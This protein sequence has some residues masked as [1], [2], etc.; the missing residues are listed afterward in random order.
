MKSVNHSFFILVFIFTIYAQTSAENLTITINANAFQILPGEEGFSAIEMEDF[1]AVSTA[2]KPQMPVKSF[3][4]AIPPGARVNHVEI[5]ANHRTEIQGQYK[6]QPV[7]PMLQ[8]SGDELSY[9]SSDY[10]RSRQEWQE[11]YQAVY[12]S[13]ALFPEKIGV[14]TNQGQWRKYHYVRV[15]FYPLQYNPRTE[16]L[17]H[18]ASCTVS[19]DYGMP[20]PGSKTWKDSHKM[21]SDNVLDDI[22]SKRIV[23]FEEAQAWYQPDDQEK[24]LNAQNQ[25]N[26][27]IIV[28]DNTM[29]GAI[30]NFKNWKEKL[31]F[32]VKVVTLDSIFTYVNG[33]D[34]PERIWNFLQQNYSGE[35]WGIRYVLLIGDIDVL[36]MRFLCPNNNGWPYSSDFYYANL[37]QNWDVDNDD[38]WGEPY[39]DNLDA[40]PDVLVGRI[41]SNSPMT[42]TSILNNYISFEQ[43][44]GAWKRHAL[45]SMGIMDYNSSGK[46]DCA[47]LGENHL[48]KSI[49]D[50]RGW[51]YTTQYEKDGISPSTFT[52]TGALSD[53]NF[54]G[55][56]GPEKNGVVNAVA[57][58][59][60]GGMAGH[61][62]FQDINGDGQCNYSKDESVNEATYDWFSRIDNIPANVQSVVFLCGCST[63]PLISADNTQLGSSLQ[64][65]RTPMR[66]LGKTYILNGAP[67]VIASTAGSDYRQNWSKPQDGAAQSLNYYFFNELITK[68]LPAGDAFYNATID[69][70]D[71]H[72]WKR[73]VRVFNYY[74]DPSIGLK[75]VDYRPGG[76]DVV[77]HDSTNWGFAVEY[78]SNGDMYTAVITTSNTDPGHIQIY[79]SQ[80]HGST[81]LKWN[82]MTGRSPFLD[83]EV[84][85]G[86]WGQDEFED[87]RLLVFYSTS[88]GTQHVSRFPLSGGVVQNV[89]ISSE[90][91]QNDVIRLTAAR[92]PSS[93]NYNVYFAYEVFDS[94][95]GNITIKVARSLNN[96]TTWQDWDSFPGYSTPSIDAGVNKNVYLAVRGQNLPHHVHIFRSTDAGENWS[97]NTNVTQNFGADSYGEPT[98]AASSDPGAP[99]VWVAYPIWKN[100]RND[101]HYTFSKNS[102]ANWDE[103]YVLAQNTGLSNTV[104]MKGYNA[105]PNQW[106]NVAFINTYAEPQ[107]YWRYSAGTTPDAWS[108][109]RIVNDFEAAAFTTQPPRLV[110]SPGSAGTGSG[111]IYAGIKKLYFT[112]PWLTS[113]ND[114]YND[115]PLEKLNLKVIAEE[116]KIQLD[117]ELKSDQ[118]VAIKIY[119]SFGELV[120]TLHEAQL[121]AGKHTLHWDGYN[122]AGEKIQ[123]GNYFCVV[124]TANES[125]YKGFYWK[126]TVS[127]QP[128]AGISDF[129]WMET[130]K[131]DN[132]FMVTDLVMES[133]EIQYAA[134][135]T[136]I[137]ANLNEG[138]VFR[139]EN[140]GESWQRLGGM[141]A[142]WSLSCLHQINEEILLAGGLAL[143]DEGPYGAIYRSENRG[144]RWDPVLWFPEGV[145][146]DI[147]QTRDGHFYAAT[148]WNGLIFKSDDVGLEW[149]P[150]AELG[151]QIHIYSL[152]QDAHGD[153]FAGIVREGNEGQILFS[154]DSGE[155]WAAAEGLEGVTAVYSLLDTDDKIY[156]GVSGVDMGWVYE[157]T[158]SGRT[159]SKTAELTNTEV[160]AVYCLLEYVPEN[161]DIPIL[162]AGTEMKRGLS[163]TEIYAKQQN[164]PNWQVFGGSLDMANAVYTIAKTSN[165]IL[166]G[167]G[168]MYG[169]IYAYDTE[170]GTGLENQKNN[171]IPQTFDLA[172]NYPNPFNPKTEIAYQLPKTSEVEITIYNLQ[173]QRVATL[174]RK[175][176]PAGYYK[177]SWDGLND[178]H[179]AI[180]SGIYFYRMLAGEYSRTMRMLYIK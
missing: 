180:A 101:I 21:L 93:T 73:G 9:T 111:V 22:I 58:G 105:S 7:K 68:D 177:I 47:V 11:N 110:Y 86:K 113:E 3:M 94:N 161:S 74:G 91:G 4:I 54:V 132:S 63:G 23:N 174:V 175:K 128:I 39:D 96:G 178:K 78:D 120:K 146:T 15:I 44:T 140:G 114:F 123:Q 84:V 143:T 48:K 107:V 97:T 69:F 127:E 142:C 179:Q 12:S 176:Q 130:G 77:I 27:L 162:L 160:Q 159:W 148:G 151:E 43:N 137:D 14:Y 51:T 158:T 10:Q 67:T 29:R 102:G 75:G 172:Q 103:D 171:L 17:I 82:S 167:T 46:T 60:P 155:E 76:T 150:I 34:D 134:T 124:K 55:E 164:Q 98:V 65:L 79:K 32:G 144:Q 168:F 92:D 119:S 38:R 42:V 30:V 152:M 147:I 33:G 81:W 41:P 165:K 126:Q 129:N 108:V 170:Q 95:S 83:V 135:V 40:T 72:G 59:S 109:P 80:D 31:G 19:V 169:N 163:Y 45:F 61:V 26:Y 13:N 87:N 117:F 112:A 100:S 8:S 37:T 99:T 50:P 28:R 89:L 70:V 71:K 156:A 25:Y 104:Y 118:N 53:N 62:W 157:S 52:S 133:P 85:V 6:I 153:L 16:Q 90:G 1:G 49:F 36:P 131:L 138:C 2:G 64:I 149:S 57:H 173:G 5:T 116:N 115:Q 145:V 166:A 125:G 66:S 122:N 106:M 24:K 154:E 20:V 139:T 18:Y 141:E 56:L 136:S 121:R 88:S 35:N